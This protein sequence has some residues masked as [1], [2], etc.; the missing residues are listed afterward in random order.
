MTGWSRKS[1]ISLA[2]LSPG[3]GSTKIPFFRRQELSVHPQHHHELAHHFNYTHHDTPL[4]IAPI[5]TPTCF[6]IDP[7]I[8]PF[9]A[10]QPP[11]TVTN[12]ILI[13]GSRS[14]S[15]QRILTRPRKDTTDSPFNIVS[16][17]IFSSK[18]ESHT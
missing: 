7:G 14:G 10:T 2:R 16:D 9:C 3:R 4:R 11:D 13:T 17:P 15:D 18:I 12:K 8:R 1:V 5:N 6:F